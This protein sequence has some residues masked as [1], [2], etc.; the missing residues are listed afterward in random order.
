MNQK[1]LNTELSMIGFISMFVMELNLVIK[2]L[3]ILLKNG[4]VSLIY[5]FL[6]QLILLDSLDLQL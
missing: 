1:K 4:E 3:R 6:I 5:L 2:Q